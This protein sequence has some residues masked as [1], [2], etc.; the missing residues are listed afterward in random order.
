MI[1]ALRTTV[2]YWR[3]RPIWAAAL[4]ALITALTFGGPAAC[5]V[6][7]LLLD[8]THHQLHVALFDDQQRHM[9]EHH[10][11][12]A[13]ADCP[14]AAQHTQHSEHAEPSALTVAI[15]LPL[16]LLPHLLGVR[17]PR[18]IEALLGLSI[19]LQPPRRP[20]RLT[21]S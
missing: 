14:I 8:A 19:A 3:K 6:H 12:A 17:F 7:C 4:A 5:F 18:L 2:H 11:A 1:S 16:A 21:H 13:Q 10:R 9:H 20:P 15:L